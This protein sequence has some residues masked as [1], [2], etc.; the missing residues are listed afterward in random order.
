MVDASQALGKMAVDVKNL[1][2]DF[3][4]LAGHKFY[5]PRTGALWVR[6]PAKL[7]PLLFGG[8]Q[9]F[10]LRSGTENVADAVGLSTAAELVTTD[11]EL[12]IQKLKS[13][14]DRLFEGLKKLSNVTL[15]SAEPML[16]NTLLVSIPGVSK[17]LDHLRKKII[18]STGAACHSGATVSEVLSRLSKEN[19]QKEFV[20]QN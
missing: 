5:A 12:Q 4:I 11:L 8:N 6:E 10:G 2:C 18:F 3:L 19:N 13:T 14:R 17:K 9:E 20:D 1:N 15:L 16:P 7:E